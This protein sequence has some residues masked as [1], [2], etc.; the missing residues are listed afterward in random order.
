MALGLLQ[1]KAIEESDKD[2]EEVAE[3]DDQLEADEFQQ[4]EAKLNEEN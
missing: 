4:G 2:A 3:E 1:P